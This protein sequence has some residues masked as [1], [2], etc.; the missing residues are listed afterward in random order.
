M[1]S[2]SGIK[3]IYIYNVFMYLYI[4]CVYFMISPRRDQSAA[5]TYFL[6]E[7]TESEKADKSEPEASGPVQN[8]LVR[9]WMYYRS[10][11]HGEKEFPLRNQQVSSFC[12]GGDN[13]VTNMD[14]DIEVQLQPRRF[15]Q[16]LRFIYR[17]SLTFNFYF[18]I[19]SILYLCFF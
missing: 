12:G 18:C 5:A 10:L 7:K 13:S 1:D 15:L 8:H 11:Q 17:M 16:L 4:Y 6:R 19:S 14:R 2:L 9:E 3:E